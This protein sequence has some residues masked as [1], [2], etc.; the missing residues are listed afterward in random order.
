MKILFLILF[1]V[2]LLS[3]SE[4]KTNSKRHQQEGSG[5]ETAKSSTEPAAVKP[6][7]YEQR[8]G[9]HLYGR[10]CAVCHGE[11][12]RGDGFNAFNLDPKPRDFTDVQYMNALTN[13]RLAETVTQ[14]GKG[15]NK[16]PLMPS[17]GGTLTKEEIENIVSYLRLLGTSNQ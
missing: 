9:K 11:E 6:P 12:G 8:Q 3:C 2:L 5:I 13:A 17:W 14:G 16:S 10:Y 4:E 7:T 15:V 1:S